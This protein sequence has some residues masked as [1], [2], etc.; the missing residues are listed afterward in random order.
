MIVNCFRG[1][2][3]GEPRINA[4]ISSQL[5]TVYKVPESLFQLEDPTSTT[6]LCFATKPENNGTK[7]MPNCSPNRLRVGLDPITIPMSASSK[8]SKSPTEPPI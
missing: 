7:E 3:D 5:E 2:Y 4:C 8:Q 1:I 6:S